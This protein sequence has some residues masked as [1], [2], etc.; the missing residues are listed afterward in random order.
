MK[1]K[2]SLLEDKRKFCFVI[3][4]FMKSSWFHHEFCI[5]T[6]QFAM[7]LHGGGHFVWVT[8]LGARFCK[9]IA[10]DGWWPRVISFRT[11]HSLVVALHINISPEGEQAYTMPFSYT[12][13]STYVQVHD[14]AVSCSCYVMH[15]GLCAGES[16]LPRMH[17]ITK[18]TKQT[19]VG[20]VFLFQIFAVARWWRQPF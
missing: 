9:I 14:N 12:C 18:L 17:Y 16:R 3:R 7:W 1:W 10:S 4:H 11:P 8:A 2:F 13:R 20:R 5:F 6:S 15:P 19:L